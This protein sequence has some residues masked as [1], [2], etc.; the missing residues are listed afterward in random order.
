MLHFEL[1]LILTIKQSTS[2]KLT[3][4]YLAITALTIILSLTST[5][6]FG[7]FGIRATAQTQPAKASFADTTYNDFPMDTV[8]MD[9]AWADSSWTDS[10][11]E[12]DTDQNPGTVKDILN[13]SAQNVG[14][15]GKQTLNNLTDKATYETGQFLNRQADKLVNGLKR[16]LSGK[17]NNH[18]N[19]QMNQQGKEKGNL[20]GKNGANGQKRN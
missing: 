7:Q 14:E 15:M 13:Q 8:G 1:V 16:K 12:D 6:V 5:H 10:T 17:N 20:V 9:S 11:W 3:M 2:T 4:K 19:Q 18:Q